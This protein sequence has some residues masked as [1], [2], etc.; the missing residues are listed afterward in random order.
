MGFAGLAGGVDAAVEHSHRARR[1]LDARRG[2][3]GAVGADRLDPLGEA[4]GEIVG[5]IE[6]LRVGDVALLV[7]QL[8]ATLGVKALGRAVVDDPVRL[9]D[10]VL[11][12][13]LDAADGGDRVVVLVVDELVGFD[14]ELVGIA[15]R[16][17]LGRRRLGQRRPGDEDEGE[18]QRQTRQR[19]AAAASASVGRADGAAHQPSSWCRST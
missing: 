16:R 8:G 10:P 12:I 4:G 11:V 9:Q 17:P 13:E 19:A 7:G 18:P 3:A 14:D 5:E 1:A 6:P 15:R 2:E